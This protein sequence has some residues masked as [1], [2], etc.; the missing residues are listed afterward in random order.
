MIIAYIVPISVSVSDPNDTLFTK[1][2]KDHLKDILPDYMVPNM[3]VTLDR[4]PMTP[5]GKVDRNALPEPTFS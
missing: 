5:S 3:F 2:L 4:F 1:A